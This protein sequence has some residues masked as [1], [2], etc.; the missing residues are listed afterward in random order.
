[1]NALAALEPFVRA[2]RAVAPA[3]E[4]CGVCAAAIDDERHEH[5]VDLEQR[6]LLC[7]CPPCTTL[8][9]H[10][11]GQRYRVVPKRV[12]IEPRF[13]LE[14]EQW[15]ALAIPVRLAFLFYNTRL[16]RWVAL[17]PSPGGAAEAEIPAAGL[18]QLAAVTN[19]IAEVQPDVEALLIYGRRGRT[20]ETFLVPIDA[21]YRLVGEVRRHWQGFHGGDL[22]WQHIESFFA[23][24]RARALPCIRAGS[25][26]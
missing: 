22:V 24:L 20:L 16:A 23:E 19:L 25:G 2:W 15:A 14:D 1:M 12:L 11:P 21:C 26:G 18:Q 10:R 4:R 8:F 13:R 7:T 3:P 5:M 9:A 6:A 17:Y